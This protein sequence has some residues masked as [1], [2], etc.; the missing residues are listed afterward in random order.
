MYLI[1][2][3]NQL[4]TALDKIL[5]VSLFNESF[6]NYYKNSQ[7]FFLFTFAALILPPVDF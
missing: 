7:I 5:Q 4:L 2:T 3:I 1:S 6:V